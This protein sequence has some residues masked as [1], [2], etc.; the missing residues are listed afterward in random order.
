MLVLLF[1]AQ[2][3][4]VAWSQAKHTGRIKGQLT[5]KGARQPLENAS[6]ALLNARDS[7]MATSTFTD[8]KGA[9]LLEGLQEGK[10]QLYISFMGYKPLLRPV[11]ITADNAVIDLGGLEMEKTGLTLGQIEI[12][13]LKPPVVVKKDTLEFNAG[14]FKV[15]ENAVV[16]ELL[17]KVPGVQVEKD[18][19][20]TAQGEPIKRILIDGKPFFGDDPKLAT[21]NLPA[22]IVEK[23]QLIDK[24]T[25]QAEFTGIKDGETIKA[26][27]ITTK[28]DSRNG[29]IGRASAGYGTD[30]RFAV[31]ATLNRF[32]DDQQLTILAGGNNVN[33]MGYSMQDV[34]SGNGGRTKS[35]MSDFSAGAG[36]G[37]NRNW[38]AGVNYSEDFGK[39][40]KVSGSYFA[41]DQRMENDYSSARQN[42]LQ[43]TTYYYNQRSNS[44]NRN[45][46]HNANVRLEYQIDSMHSLIITPNFSYTNSSNVQENTYESLGDKQQLVNSGSSRNTTTST[47][48]NLSANALFRKRFRK[49]GRT[50][51]LNL[52]YNYTTN[53]QENFNNSASLFVLPGGQTKNDSINQRNDIGSLARNT[54]LRLV[55]T[56]PV[57]RDR[58]LEFSYAYTSSFNS[59][60]K[61]TYD[62]DASKGTYSRLNDSLSNAF[63]NT[64]VT[65]QAGV[66]I[67]TQ[68]EKYDYSLGLNVQLSDLDNHNLSKPGNDLKQHTVNFFPSAFFNYAFTPSRRI[69][70]YYQ[71]STQQPSV[72]QLQP[73]PDNSNPLYIQEGNP[74]LKPSFNNMFGLGYNAF[75]RETMIGFFANLNGSFATNKIVSASRYDSLGRQISKPVNVNGSYNTSANLVN[76]FPLKKQGAFI[77]TTTALAY[78]QDVSYANDVLGNTK[79][80][81]VIQG[82][83][84]NYAYKELLDFSTAASFNYTG[85]RYSL[86]KDNNTNFFNYTF[87]FDMSVN[88]PL[89][90]IIGGDV[91]Y[92]LNTGRSAGYNQ[93]V[94]MLNAF[95]SK[96]V[97]RNKQGLIRLQGFDL[98]N[99]NVSINRN[100]GENFIEDVQTTV[101]KRYFMLSFSY[102]L[103]KLGGNGGKGAA[104]AVRSRTPAEYRTAAGMRRS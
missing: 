63:E 33:N 91:D 66:S 53:D 67:R 9:F 22:N 78:N 59:S 23:I 11:Q 42:L 5:D 77:N 52:N 103:H 85:A 1:V 27:N 82:V 72:T 10:Y 68:K 104:K 73:V 19:T 28:K 80:F 100:V 60:D 2:C 48:P 96:S 40:L 61:L 89:G 69:H 44:L 18:G 32:R 29:L 74:D 17:K 58:F 54:G 101:L 65:H 35:T 95:I 39:K 6:V 46:S 26:I 4:A 24:K 14:S 62:F 102:F 49:A 87:S 84:F 15:R 64:F 45:T 93:D 86:Q 13:S 50:L 31:N 88:L 56:E 3:Y 25:E 47:S 79:N 16:E 83:N 37:I 97:F 51:S 43:D 36:G 20:I 57:F 7:S 81:S 38:N 76:T 99:Q 21:K 41:G 55:Y 30:D 8:K 90:F 71:G 92:V 34:Y 70:F 98:L 12:V 75:N 94:T